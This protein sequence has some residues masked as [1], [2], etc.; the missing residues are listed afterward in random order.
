MDTYRYDAAPK[1]IA[2]GRERDIDIGKTFVTS[3]QRE[4]GGDL[5][6]RRRCHL[7]SFL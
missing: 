3:M 2:I 6:C 5:P 1:D 7:P 4:A